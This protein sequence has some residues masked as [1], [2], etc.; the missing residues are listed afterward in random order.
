LVYCTEAE[1]TQYA[2]EQAF[3]II[4]CS[5]CGSQP[6]LQRRRVKQLI[7]D[8]ARENGSVPNNL[9]AALE[10]VRPSHLLDRALLKDLTNQQEQGT[11][12]IRH[13]PLARDTSD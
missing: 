8:L 1:L 5:Y 10:N 6:N 9:M 13:T 12:E 3:P 11:T 2:G 7:A 4:P